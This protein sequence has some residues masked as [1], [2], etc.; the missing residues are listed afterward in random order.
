M[1]SRFNF[2]SI[3]KG[4]GAADPICPYVRTPMVVVHERRWIQAASGTTAGGL[5]SG[6]ATHLVLNIAHSSA[7]VCDVVFGLDI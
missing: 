5:T 4:G 2:S 7:V 1:F 6:F 3:F